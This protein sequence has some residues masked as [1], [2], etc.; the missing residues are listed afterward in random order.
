LTNYAKGRRF[1]Y[2]VRDH[3]LDLGYHVVRSASSQGEADLVATRAGVVL[4]VQAKSRPRLDPAEWNQLFDVAVQSGAVPVYVTKNA[5][6]G[7]EF[8]R[9]TAHKIPR[10]RHKP[11]EP[12]AP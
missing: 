12:F 1:E 11:M 3:L 2:R 8:W 5:K 7:L 10:K 6:R 9:L 4:F